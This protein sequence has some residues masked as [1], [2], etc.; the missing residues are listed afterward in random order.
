MLFISFLSA[1]S[2]G[3]IIAIYLSRPYLRKKA[4]VQMVFF[5]A[6]A[7]LIS[8]LSTSFG[9]LNDGNPL[10]TAQGLLS[11][12]FPLSSVIWSF[13]ATYL[14]YSNVVI[15]KPLVVKPIHHVFNWGFPIFLTCLIYITNR[16]G[17][18]QGRG[19]CFV[20]N[21]SDSPV[22]SLLFWN[23]MSFYGWIILLVVMMAVLIVRIHFQTIKMSRARS[24]MTS[25]AGG[26][27]SAAQITAIYIYLCP[28]IITFSWIIP[29]IVD[30]YGVTTGTTIK[31]DSIIYQLSLILPLFQG[32][33]MTYIFC[34]MTP[35]IRKIVLSHLRCYNSSGHQRKRINSS[36]AKSNLNDNIINKRR[37]TMFGLS[38]IY[39]RDSLSYQIRSMRSRTQT[40]TMRSV[41]THFTKSKGVVK[42]GSISISIP[43]S[44]S[45]MIRRKY[46]LSSP[47][48]HVTGKSFSVNMQSPAVEPTSPFAPKSPL[49]SRLPRSPKSP[50]FK[51]HIP[52]ETCVQIP[53]QPSRPQLSSSPE[54]KG[55]DDVRS[56]R[57]PT[58][59]SSVGTPNC[60]T[61]KPIA[62][63]SAETIARRELSH[64][65]SVEHQYEDNTIV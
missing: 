9:E 22:W 17:E 26:D 47:K 8:S 20:A 53:R 62:S 60:N 46:S 23:I 15:L 14:L 27:P 28:V 6:I 48:I 39:S 18:P 65:E 40:Q 3:I 51:A 29:L 61:D 19:W 37:I 34:S 30:T 16:I 38:Q 54:E 10:C 1:V 25:R 32:M 55:I 52:L 13:S 35:F 31:H 41:N 11:N 58:P 56:Y 12:I 64:H 5:T 24:S 33:I 44:L 21:R 49:Y 63:L 57:M 36:E 4:Y 43:D 7:D 45:V 42:S 50:F 59:R 2:S